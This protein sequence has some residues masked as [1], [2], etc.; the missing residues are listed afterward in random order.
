MAERDTGWF[1]S[2]YSTGGSNGCVEVRITDTGVGV[3]DSKNPAGPSFT[4]R[5]E[6]WAKFV[7]GLAK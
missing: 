7:G 6:A 4:F 2:S 1:K 3:R 5:A